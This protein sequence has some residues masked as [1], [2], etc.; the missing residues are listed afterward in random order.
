[1]KKYNQAEI[2]QIPNIFKCH[3]YKEWID[4]QK[5]PQEYLGKLAI[6]IPDQRTKQGKL[7]KANGW[8]TEGIDFEIV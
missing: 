5:K 3:W 4:E 6:L 2:E 1:M 8:I 7:I